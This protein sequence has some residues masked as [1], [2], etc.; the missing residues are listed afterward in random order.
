MKKLKGEPPNLKRFRLSYLLLCA[1]ALYLILIF[2][3]FPEF[4]ESASV[5]SGGD[6]YGF[7][8]FS[9]GDDEDTDM[10]KAHHSS[11]NSDGL[12]R[13]LQH[14]GNQDD[15]L[16]PQEE[17]L[18][19]RRKG[20]PSIKPL[21]QQY[22][23]ITSE[24]LR[25]MNRTNNLSVL[26]RMA[27]EAWALGL[28]AWEEVNKYDEKEINMTA[29]LEGKPELCPSWVSM[30]GED[31][32][33]RDLIMFLPC[34]LAAGSSITVIGT[35]HVAHQ[36]YVPQL[37]KVR[38]GDALVMVSQF[39]VELQ[40]L[41]SVDGED[42]PKILHLNPRLRGD[43]SHQQVIEHNTCYRMQWGM[44]QRCDGLPSK[45]DDDMRVD[46]YLRCEKWMRNGNTIDTKE[47]KIFSWFQR[48]IGRAKKPQV[49][50]PFPFRE[51][52]MFVLTIRAGVD[53]YHINVGGRH[54]TS[55]P[56]RMGF[57][58]EDATGLAIK[59]DVDVH[60]V[61]ATSLPTSHPSF[62]PQ[63]VL[64]FSEKW[65][66]HPIPKHHIQL[67][68]GVLSASNH[69]AERMAVRKTWMQSLP[70]KSSKV[71]VRF[72][73]AL[74]SL[75]LP[76]PSHGHCSSPS[77]SGEEK[78]LGERSKKK[79]K[80]RNLLNEESN[81]DEDFPEQPENPHPKPSYSETLRNSRANTREKK[82]PV[83]LD[84]SYVK[85]LRRS[86][87]NTLILKLDGRAINLHVLSAKIETLWNLRVGHKNS[88][89]SVAQS[90][91][92][93]PTSEKPAGT[94][95]G[96]DVN[97][98]T[99]PTYGEW[100]QNPRSEVNAV[101]KKEAAYFGDIEILPFMDRYEL[102]VLKTVA[103]CEYGVRNVSASYIMKC[104]DDT[105]IR[106]ET[107]LKEIEA[108]SPRRAL[109]LGNLNL[110]HRPLRIG[111]WAVSY[112]EWPE[113]IYPPYANGP[114]YVISSDIAKYIVSQRANHSL[115][116]FKM[117]DVSM[118]MWVEQ[119]NSTVNVQYSHNWK[120]CQ[121]GC[122][123]DY[124][125]AHYQSPR[126]MI[127]LWDNLMKGRAHCCNV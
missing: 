10:T 43:W 42:P 25:R 108:V 90:K 61:H 127:C 89:C 121:Y 60:S 73:V 71:A 97:T 118:G 82:E 79:V 99:D 109:Y 116:L 31:L 13:I 93:A 6:S 48:F 66:S 74:F 38:P 114:G 124:Y 117:E 49:T 76:L 104:D 18:Q 125:T 119:F 7:D 44:A 59:G 20:R 32:E 75:C 62:S 88:E 52:R 103:I 68:I 63:K 65:K 8:G 106:L 5:L 45:S 55:F 83:V 120:F 46:G 101:L 15:A 17:D 53:G 21:Q 78:E 26:E 85:L 57:T 86:R 123:Q 30:S 115:R 3:K 11:V 92:Q 58:L 40:G 16:K 56:Y 14:N 28:K 9:L 19:K 113:E 47:S 70:I 107:V 100:L 4:L 80:S 69:F 54:V 110:L 111:K 23:R 12:H 94:D 84:E 39:M 95:E 102:V 122:M 27:N 35:P 105:F 96:G 33:K 50:W 24:V 126:Q 64:D 98:K 77:F 22:G 36:E 2:V 34:G 1:A 29:V 37:A 72:F 91:N 81:M 51:G 41:K 67:F 112:E 87:S